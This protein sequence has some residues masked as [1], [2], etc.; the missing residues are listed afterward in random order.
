MSLKHQKKAF[1][2]GLKPKINRRESA[3]AEARTYLRGKGI[4]FGSECRQMRLPC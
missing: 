1:P 4:R 3:R 2:G